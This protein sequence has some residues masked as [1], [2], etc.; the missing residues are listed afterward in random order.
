MI[1]IFYTPSCQTGSHIV[2]IKGIPMMSLLGKSLGT[3]SGKA[4]LFTQI[5]TDFQLCSF[6]KDVVVLKGLT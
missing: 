6:W 4:T 2:Y 1:A 3:G 5:S